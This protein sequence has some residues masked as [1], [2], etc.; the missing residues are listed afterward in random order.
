MVETITDD[1]VRSAADTTAV[2]VLSAFNAVDTL[3]ANAVVFPLV[4]TEDAS[5][6]T[7]VV[8]D[9]T[10][11]PLVTPLHVQVPMVVELVTPDVM[12]DLTAAQ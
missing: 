3:V 8:V 1:T 12:A 6:I 10:L 11:D 4:T 7:I 5:P 9:T 2:R